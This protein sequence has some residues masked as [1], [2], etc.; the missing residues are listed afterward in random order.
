MCYRTDNLQWNKTKSE[1]KR[2]SVGVLMNHGPC[3]AKV[4]ADFFFFGILDWG[5]GSV[6][7]TV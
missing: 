2:N 5:A 1:G 7:V 3:I 6:K 4:C